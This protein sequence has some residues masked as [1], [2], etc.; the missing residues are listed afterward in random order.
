MPNASSKK[1]EPL[2]NSRII[3]SYI[4]LIKRK[5]PSVNIREMLDYAAMKPQEVDD[6]GHWFTQT[7]VDR[8]Y[9]Q[10]VAL[11]GNENI[12]REAGRYAA[13]PDSI[14][15]MRQYVLGLSTPARVYELIGKTTQNFTRSSKYESRL[16]SPN[17]V[18]IIVSPHEG[19]VEKPFQC[20]NRKGFFEAILMV[21]NNKPPQ[22]EHPECMF[23]GHKACRYIIT[24]EKNFNAYYKILRN[25]LI[26]L[27]LI[28]ALVSI[29][30]LPLKS[31]VLLVAALTIA[32][33][34]TTLIGEY[35]DKK[36]LKAAMQNLQE[37]SDQLVNQIEINYNNRLVTREIGQIINRRYNLED[38]LKEV[39]AV[40]KHRLDFD[41]GMIM[42]AN[43]QKTQLKFWGGFGYT[44][45]QLQFLRRL[46]FHLDN[47]SSK[48]AFVI[49]FRE[50][51]PFL[52][53]NINEIQDT[54]SERSVNFA[55]K[56]GGKS[57]ICC[58]I[59]C[60][61]ESIGIFAVDNIRSKRLLVHSDVSLLMGISHFIGIF[62][63]HTEHLEARQNQLKSILKVLVSSIDAR[64]T[65][66]KGHSEWVAEYSVG[67]CDQLGLNKDYRE[68]IRIAA[69]LHDYG[70]LGIPDSML[71]KADKLT[72]YEYEYVKLHVD[73]TKEILS[74]INF[75]GSLK[76]VPEIAGAH[77][78][79]MDGSGYPMGLKGE[80]IPF[81]GRIIAVADYFEALTANRYY[82]EPMPPAKA[83]DMLIENNGTFFDKQI[84][85]A[86]IQYYMRVY[87]DTVR[88]VRTKVS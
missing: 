77:H 80:E 66:T 4:K 54:L 88:S 74:E 2:Y 16:I 87:G 51:K 14:G 46:S 19:T 57:F 5:Y 61:E 73:K 32:M 72:E 39:V 1:E 34:G 59:I 30:M 68:M 70:K 7:Q 71:K 12:A 13:S 55:K 26:L 9:E 11:T 75:E 42:L 60:D 33:L 15:A 84:V 83:L 62:I 64:D 21:F 50:Q 3:N 53:N 24:W 58:P 69:L 86:F 82:S 49:S 6:Q 47:P 67:I 43:P 10:A 44:D 22:I 36:S 78:E 27:M 65:V 41:R 38:V 76:E 28:V 35:L 85:N 23:R 17:K 63:R 52:I 81:G 29:A 48:G 20:E 18:E 40:L 79:K 56:M 45:D 25:Y 37:A 31:W 8:F